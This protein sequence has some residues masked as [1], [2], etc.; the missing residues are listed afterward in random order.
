[1]FK[2]G[3]ITMAFSE[4]RKLV[5]AVPNI[6]LSRYQNTIVT[7]SYIHDVGKALGGFTE[8]VATD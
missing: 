3:G 7:G 1:M 8:L 4:L 2:V 5:R 6:V